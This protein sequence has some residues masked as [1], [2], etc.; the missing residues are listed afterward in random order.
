MTGL[1]G[2]SASYTQLVWIVATMI[3]VA[4][5]VGLVVVYRRARARAELEEA[6]RVIEEAFSDLPATSVTER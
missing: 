6:E 1:A 4:M 2:H 3:G 5:L